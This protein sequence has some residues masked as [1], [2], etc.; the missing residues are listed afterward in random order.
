MKTYIFTCIL[1]MGLLSSV[2]SCEGNPPEIINHKP[3]SL[4]SLIRLSPD[5]VPLLVERGKNNFKEYK[6][7]LAMIDAAKAF[8]LDSNNLSARLL[9]AQI[10]NNRESR[11]LGD[12]ITA[13]RHYNIVVKKQPKNTTALVGLASTF[14]F[15][16]DFERT[17]QYVNEAL[18][19]NPK[20]RDAYVLKGTSYLMLKNKDLAKSS[21]ET[22]IQRDPEFFA[23]YFILGQIYQSEDNPICVEY[24]TTAQKLEPNNLEVKYQVA[25]TR[26]TYGQIEGA[27]A[28]YREMTKDT[29]ELYVSRGLFHQGN[30][31]RVEKNIDSALY[32]FKSAIETNPK[33]VEAWYNL[34]LCH[35]SKGNREKA[36][37]AY[38]N[39]LKFDTEYTL[40]RD[41]ANEI[42]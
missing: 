34:G 2:T 7:D 36:L 21:Y 11:S 24:F 18:R 10:L 31:H 19:I 28:M 15:Q 37:K 42:K 27:K 40:A 6:H 25:F 22:A 13:Q 17:F 29:S 39:C 20:F 4:D 35:Q 38:S 8:R 33:Y 32:F 16:Q 30:L 9:Y 5:S 12:I 23:A 3:L 26:E 1:L 14:L 41:R